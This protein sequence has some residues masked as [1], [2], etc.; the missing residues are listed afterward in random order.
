MAGDLVVLLGTGTSVSLDAAGILTLASVAWAAREY[1]R[2]R[3]SSNHAKLSKLAKGARDPVA[4]GDG[5]LG[6][7]GAE[8]LRLQRASG[9]AL[10]LSG[11]VEALAPCLSSLLGA[12]LFCSLSRTRDGRAVRLSV[13]VGSEW[14]EFYAADPDGASDLGEGLGAVLGPPST[15][16]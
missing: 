6:E 1:R 11:I 15:P 2:N 13:K 9:A 10:D 14:A 7:I 4:A 16:T 5:R 12:D 3:V 8:L